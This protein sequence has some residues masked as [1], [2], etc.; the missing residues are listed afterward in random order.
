MPVPNKVQGE[1]LEKEPKASAL[2]VQEEDVMCAC[3][4]VLGR[5]GVYSRW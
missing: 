1:H 5:G 3:V 2:L 4:C